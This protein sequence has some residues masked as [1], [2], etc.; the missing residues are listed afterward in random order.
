MNL[1]TTID[2]LI[3]LVLVLLSLS[4]VV[5]SVQGALK[6]MLKLKSQAKFDLTQ[7]FHL[8]FRL[9]MIACFINVMCIFDDIE[10]IYIH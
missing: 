2:I 8:E 1:G 5:Q 3:A 9:K 4:L 7:I 6:K 10:I